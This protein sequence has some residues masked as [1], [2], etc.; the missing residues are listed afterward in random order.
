M[1]RTG[2]SRETSSKATGLKSRIPSFQ[3]IE[4]EAEFWDTHDSTEFE[5]EFEQVTDVRFVVTRD[6][7]SKALTV[8]LPQDA[9][10]ALVQEART[11][12]KRAS[13]PRLSPRRR[14]PLAAPERGTRRRR[15]FSEETLTPNRWPRFT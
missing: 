5:D 4:E 6:G 14:R 8:R 13:A 1:A 2:T 12:G 3:G 15:G 9:F 11:Q 10:E 7:P